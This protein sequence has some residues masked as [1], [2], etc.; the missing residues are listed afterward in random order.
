M[1][2]F[3]PSDTAA[4]FME[5]LANLEAAQNHT[6]DITHKLFENHQEQINALQTQNKVLRD[7]IEKL[8]TTLTDLFNKKDTP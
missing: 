4:L 8:F 3:N 1:V 5:R 2:T 7:T 6:V